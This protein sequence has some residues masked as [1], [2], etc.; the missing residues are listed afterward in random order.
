MRAVLVVIRIVIIL[1]S[2]F[3]CHLFFLF[4][5]F[6]RVLVPCDWSACFAVFDYVYVLRYVSFESFRAFLLLGL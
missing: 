5:G 3:T 6:S 4:F 2:C 1:S